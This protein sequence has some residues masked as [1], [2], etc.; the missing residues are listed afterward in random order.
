VT[1]YLNAGPFSGPTSN[2]HMTDL[3]YQIAVGALRF[4][5]TCA[6]YVTQPHTC[7]EIEEA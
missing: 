6:A 1:Q 3:Q 2:G 7:P 4:C 5:P